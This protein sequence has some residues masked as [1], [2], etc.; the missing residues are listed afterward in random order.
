M[1]RIQH[2]KIRRMSDLFV[3]PPSARRLTWGAPALRRFEIT[4]T[5]AIYGYDGI[6]KEWRNTL[7]KGEYIE[8]VGEMAERSWGSASSLEKGDREL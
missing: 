5:G 6:P 8:E 3:L 1:I 4:P 2:E 7:I